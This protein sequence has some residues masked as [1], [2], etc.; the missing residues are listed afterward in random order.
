M[1]VTHPLIS[2][3]KPTRELVTRNVRG[4]LATLSD[5]L[6]PY[7]SMV[8]YAPLADGD[9]LF[10]LSALAEHTRYIKVNPKVSLLIAPDLNT[11]EAFSKARVTLLGEIEP[12]ARDRDCQQAFAAAH[13]KAQAY[14]MMG[15][16]GFFRMA[17]DSARFI[18]GFG[19]MSW[20]E[21]SD[22]RD[23]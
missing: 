18:G 23:A 16:F 8:D 11:P 7:A 14:M 4:V 17:V 21:G 22:Y 3:A 9:I 13:P 19:R 5:Q 15:D 12:V 2:H 1:S 6:F 10:L 20:V